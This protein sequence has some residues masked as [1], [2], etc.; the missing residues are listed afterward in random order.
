MQ[1]HLQKYKNLYQRSTLGWPPDMQYLSPRSP[2]PPPP[3]PRQ[4]TTPWTSASWMASWLPCWGLWW[5]TRPGLNLNIF[6]H[7]LVCM[8]F[9]LMLVL[10]VSDKWP[11]SS[12]GNQTF[13]RY[14]WQPRAITGLEVTATKALGNEDTSLSCLL[15]INILVLQTLLKC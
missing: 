10:P 13:C 2:R 11:T 15:S 1:N 9:R 14:F 4:S 5:R 3:T 7:K 6:S 12:T 8:L